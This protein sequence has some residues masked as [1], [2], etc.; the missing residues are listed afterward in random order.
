MAARSTHKPSRRN[1]PTVVAII[2]GEPTDIVAGDYLCIA[3]SGGGGG[4]P[5][6]FRGPGATHETEAAADRDRGQF[7]RATTD[8]YV[9]RNGTAY[10]PAVRLDGGLVHDGNKDAV[11]DAAGN[12]RHRFARSADG[13]WQHPRELSERARL[14][15]GRVSDDGQRVHVLDTAG[16]R[17]VVGRW[18]NLF[19]LAGKPTT[20]LVAVVRD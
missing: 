2:A 10:G 16:R 6:G 7:V 9:D 11:C 13:T 12:P 14:T 19:T 18:L 5:G 1:A 20:Q 4:R 8:A 15:P 3:Y 17:T